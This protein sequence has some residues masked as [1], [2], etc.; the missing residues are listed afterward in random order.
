MA[1][2]I[3]LPLEDETNDVVVR[4]SDDE[5]LAVYKLFSK[6]SHNELLSKGLSHEE[7]ILVRM[8]RDSLY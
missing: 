4:L 5:A 1:K 8:V 2:K 7:C 3:F 6:L